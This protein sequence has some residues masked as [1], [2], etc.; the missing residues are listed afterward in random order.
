M[1]LDFLQA[2]YSEGCVVPPPAAAALVCRRRTLCASLLAS[3]G[4]RLTHHVT[5]CFVRLFQK[6]Q[7]RA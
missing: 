5:S 7:G 6:T 2:D 3:L 1:Y 4:S